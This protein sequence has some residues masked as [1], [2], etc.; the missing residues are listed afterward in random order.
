MPKTAEPRLHVEVLAKLAELRLA[1]GRIEEAVRL[2]DGFEDNVATS[3]VLG[4]IHL[5]R[6]ELAVAASLIGRRAREVGEESLQGASLLELLVQVEIEQRKLAE[7]ADRARRLAD[8]GSSLASDVIV[9]RGERALGRVLVAAGDGGAVPH[10]ERALEAFARLEMPLEIARA[11]LLLARAMAEREV[12]I[13]EARA[14]LGGFERLGAGGDADS[15][16][17][18]LRSLGVRAARA[19]PR[20]V[21]VLTKRESEVLR[22]LG[23][24]LSH[25]EIAERMFITR[26]TVENHVARVLSKLE[27][28][29]R[30]EAA[31]YA[32]RHLERHR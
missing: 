28:R 23:E 26:K 25:R 22:L 11:R 4:S 27:L 8:L 6:G 21:T 17:A 1:Q 31:A 3:H 15:A 10:L 2:L 13:A 24:G 7:A 18:F 14:A 20:G 12:A 19:G 29:G 5:A 32:V 30:G 9:A 16:A